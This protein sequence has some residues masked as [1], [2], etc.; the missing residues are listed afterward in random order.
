MSKLFSNARYYI[1]I[2]EIAV[3]GRTTMGYQVLNKDTGIVEYEDTILPQ[4]IMFANGADEHLDELL[5]R[6]DDPAVEVLS[7]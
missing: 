4:A 5:G 1:R 6:T 2:D 3:D 7:H